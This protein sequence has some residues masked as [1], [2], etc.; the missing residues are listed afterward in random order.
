MTS[1][2][3]KKRFGAFSLSKGFINVEQ[4]IEALTIQVKENIEKKKHR[5][6]GEILVDLGHMDNQEATEV[7]ES[8]FEQRFGDTAVSKGLI[9]L[10]QL[11]QAMTIQVRDETEKGKHRLIGEVLV[12]TDFMTPSQV[13]RVLDSMHGSHANIDRSK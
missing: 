1:K 8:K 13:Q 11:I 10:N 5:P 6:I 12:D 2:N 3:M 9:T 4:I 7:L